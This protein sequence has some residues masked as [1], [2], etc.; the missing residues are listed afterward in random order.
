MLT[1]LTGR[2]RRLWPRVLAEVGEAHAAGAEKLLV[3]TPDQYTLQAELDLIDRLNLPGLLTIEVL[4]PSRLL[5]RVFA[6]AGSPQ[7]V[8]VDA[9][10][11][12]M[13]LLDVLRG[14]RKELRYYGGAVGRRG[15]TDRLA[16]SIGDLKRAGMAPEEV[17][18]LA[19]SLAPGDAL[20]HKLA[21]LALIYQRYEE[22]LSGAFLDGEDVQNALL[23]RMPDS[24]VFAGT[25]VWIYGFDLISPQFLRQIAVMARLCVSVRLALTLEDAA[26]RDGLAFTPARDTLARLARFFDAE[27]MRW[28]REHITAPLDTV[29]EIQHLER[30]LF[31]IPPEPF[32]GEPKGITLW[33]AATPYDEAMRAASAMRT[34]AR[35]G[36]PFSEM[37][38]VLGDAESYAGAVHAA[39]GRSGIP[40]HLSRKRPA[41]SHP[42]PRAWLAALRCVTRG[43]RAEDA[44]DW[45]KGGFCGLDRDGVE[46]LENYAIENGLRGAKWR[47]PASDMEIEALRAAFVA[48]LETLQGRLREAKD[49][50]GTLSAAFGLLEDVG[51]YRT[52]DEWQQT[53]LARGLRTEAAD[54]AQAWRLMLETLDQLHALLNGGD[55]LRNPSMAPDSSNPRRHP[56]KR[57]PMGD[58]AQVIEAGLAESELGAI[59]ATP[60]VVQVGQLGHL[61]IGEGCRLLFLLGMVDGVLRVTEESLLSDAE[62][63]RT[64]AHADAAFGLRGDALSQLMQINLLDTL[65]APSER[66]FISH[67]HAGA[68]GEAQRPA[69]VLKLL[70]RVFPDL[71]ERGSGTGQDVVAWHSPG[72]ALD[73]LGPAL[74]AAA[75]KGELTGDAAEAAAFLLRAPETRAQ[76]ERVLRAFESRGGTAPLPR[77]T[78]RALYALGDASISRLEA[79]ANCPY[80]HFV[81][82]GLRPKPR[83]AFEIRSD[84]SGTFYHRAIEGYAKLAAKAP[85]WPEITREES[86]AL[87]DSVLAPLTA[88]WEGRPLD[89]NAMLRA[90]GDSL[91]RVARRAA[92]TY[93]DQLRRGAFRTGVIE[94]RF[95]PGD[96]LP[97]VSLALPDGRTVWLKGRI[98]RIDFYQEDGDTW[99][100]VVDYKSGATKLEPSRIGAGL[101]LQLLLYLSAA[102]TAYP[103]VH[104]AGAFYSRFE[105]PLVE[106]DSRDVA[107]IEAALAE[108]LRLKG[109]VLSDVRVLHAME[110]ANDLFKKDGDVKKSAGA[111][112]AGALDALMRYARS[113]AEEIA[114]QI[115]QGEISPNPAQLDAWTACAWCDYREICGFDPAMPGHRARK[116]RKLT[117]D[118]LVEEAMGRGNE[119]EAMDGV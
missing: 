51:A 110:N 63:E 78:A 57:L 11:K 113:M 115:E 15:F 22:R 52:L 7:R 9:R 104:A 86:D 81:A 5:T 69:T 75:D 103:G 76:A 44:I 59:P 35:A 116:V 71:T 119:G 36:M 8:R 95:G 46:R 2:S 49:A 73:A 31:A 68:G 97:P 114:G 48:P 42:L 14:A 108:K 109:I 102:L 26:A 56:N 96:P 32:H 70:R 28:D 87:M 12:A 98:D 47:K 20:G 17:A 23:A 62:I 45:L 21:D 101:Q 10:G 99:L 90:T 43:W 82:H 89:D 67:A 6:L 88:E 33:A 24:G 50:T 118:A 61:K 54:C 30:E 27:A 38:V 117:Q 93:A 4:S 53:L 84:E 105:D 39:F 92:W 18:A 40:F 55:S 41:L 112:D 37:V 65:A 72:T 107:A 66:L 100:R 83:R 85:N 111:L 58:L 74:R 13:V 16:Q 79:F 94:A 29:P 25:R 3:I 64:V 34:Y 91:C 1:V 19:A 106:T 60:G 77:R 80:Q